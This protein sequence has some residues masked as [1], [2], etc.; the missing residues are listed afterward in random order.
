M[1]PELDPAEPPS[2]PWRAI[3]DGLANEN[4]QWVHQVNAIDAQSNPAGVVAYTPTE[5][6]Q[7]RYARRLVSRAYPTRRRTRSLPLPHRSLQPGQRDVPTA[8][9]VQNDQPR[10]EWLQRVKNSGVQKLRQAKDT[11]IDKLRWIGD[12]IVP[13]V[14]SLRRRNG[15]NTFIG[16][17]LGLLIALAYANSRA[18]HHKA[19]QATPASLYISSFKSYPTWLHTDPL[20]VIGL[21]A[22]V[23]PA[24]IPSRRTIQKA[25]GK[26]KSTWHT[27]KK[28]RISQR[29]TLAIVHR[30]DLACDL[31]M[32][33]H[34]NQ[35]CEKTLDSLTKF[36][37]VGGYNDSLILL[38]FPSGFSSAPAGAPHFAK[39]CACTL[40]KYLRAWSY[41]VL[42]PVD[43]QPDPPKTLEETCPC[44]L[45]MATKS[46]KSFSFDAKSPQPP[47]LGRIKKDLSVFTTDWRVLWWR[48][49]GLIFYD[50]RSF[51]STKMAMACAQG[52]QEGCER[53]EGW[54]SASDFHFALKQCRR[55]VRFEEGKDIKIEPEDDGIID[56][57]E[58]IQARE[59]E[60][61]EQKQARDDE[62]EEEFLRAW[63][64]NRTSKKW[65]EE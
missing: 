63:A 50:D 35:Y 38:P 16:M 26:Y 61:K 46:W 13:L 9:D 28:N 2:A 15:R 29:D 56:E 11:T 22:Q 60:E 53:M 10:L 45:D 51:V 57:P 47:Y 65:Y 54:T 33:Y 3:G 58:W 55:T 27:D 43:L 31:L 25:C 41:Q 64:S 49:K 30:G 1:E 24:F 39:H 59:D 20:Q 4:R 37:V 21:P 62:E 36:D 40:A 42:M 18:A 52:T 32:L 44:T 7:H 5:S 12:R 8:R 6:F 14:N 17:G 48:A 34:D 23:D 19:L